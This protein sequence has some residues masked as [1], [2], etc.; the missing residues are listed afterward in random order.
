MYAS[1]VLCNIKSDVC[2]SFSFWTLALPLPDR[3]LLRQPE[4]MRTQV[5]LQRQAR[6]Q[7]GSTATMTASPSLLH[8]IVD[9]ASSGGP[10]TR[11]S[12]AGGPTSA[13][14]S[15]NSSVSTS[16]QSGQAP[17]GHPASTARSGGARST[18]S[19]A[20]TPTTP[21]HPQAS[22]PSRPSP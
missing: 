21:T 20:L 17:V 9:Y 16:G 13:G 1:L 2:T 8:Q 4:V 14:S 5:E 12:S 10:R 6:R 7:R 19:Q 22:S 15:S 18:R 11:T 3:L